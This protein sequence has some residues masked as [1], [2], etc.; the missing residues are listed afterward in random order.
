M[1]ATYQQVLSLLRDREVDIFVPHRYIFYVV[2]G[3][4]KWYRGTQIFLH[5]DFL[6]LALR[7]IFVQFVY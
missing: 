2:V 4:Q 3:H 6:R 7:D 1:A 5:G